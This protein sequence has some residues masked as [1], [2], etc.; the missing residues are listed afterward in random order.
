V[1]GTPGTG[2]R[3]FE[4]LRKRTIA[5]H[6]SDRNVF[7]FGF[8]PGGGHRPYFLTRPAALWLERRLDFPNWTAESI[9][10]MP[11]THISEWAEKNGV[12][13]DKLFSTELREGGTRALGTGVPAIPHDQLNSLPT[14]RW[15]REKDRYV[16]ET[17]VREAQKRLGGK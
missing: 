2:Q 12:A 9:A 1:V 5:L 6:G 15:E 16:Y 10:K 13:I 17:W 3:F 4:D 7:D 14:D 8:E 11:E